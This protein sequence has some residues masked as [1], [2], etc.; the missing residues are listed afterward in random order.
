MSNTGAYD[1]H[2]PGVAAPVGLLQRRELEAAT[3]WPALPFAKPRFD[4]RHLTPNAW[5][6]RFDVHTVLPYDMG[7]GYRLDQPRGIARILPHQQFQRAETGFGAPDTDGSFRPRGRAR[8]GCAGRSA[9]VADTSASRQR[10]QAPL[11]MSCQRPRRLRSRQTPV[12]KDA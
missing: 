9:G 3:I 4:I 8:Y 11:L 12:H 6:K 7:N 1:L 5:T 10:G 2:S